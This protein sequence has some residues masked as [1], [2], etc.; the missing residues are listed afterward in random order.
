[1]IER[2][3]VTGASSGIGAA[4]VEAFQREGAEV[5]GLDQAPSSSADDH[6]QIDVADPTCGDALLEFCA[7]RPVDGLV[8]NAGIGLDKAASATTSQDFDRVMAVNARAPFLLA[9]ALQPMLA[10]RQGFVV[11]VA[12]VHAVATST[13]VAAYAASKGALVSMTRA[14]A[15]EWAPQVRVNAVLP[16]AIDTEML[17]SGLFRTDA[18][19]DD[20]AVRHPMGRVGSVTEIA[21]TAVFLARNK[22]MTG[23]TVVV[24]GGATARLSTE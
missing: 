19:L 16:G 22:F 17:R 5:L 6:L 7:G 3:V 20:L 23:A 2:V 18:T 4:C 24:D 14:L 1:M 9:S 12:S 11:N 13:S 8:N 10:V 21:D 15:L